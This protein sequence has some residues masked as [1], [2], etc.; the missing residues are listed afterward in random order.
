M[1]V[2]IILARCGSKG[3]VDK[4]I[5]QV[6]SEKLS[7]I[8]TLAAVESDIFDKIIYSSDS[9]A[10]LEMARHRFGSKISYH[11]RTTEAAGDNVSSWSAVEEVVTDMLEEIDHHITLLGGSCATINAQD[12]YLFE[13]KC[14]EA[15]HHGE[16]LSVKRVSYP[17][18]NTF[19][20][21]KNRIV[22]HQ[23]SRKLACR[24]EAKHIWQ[25]DGHIYKR[26]I[27]RLGEPF[28]NI[29]TLP[30]SLSKKIYINV[31]TQEDLLLAQLLMGDSGI[32]RNTF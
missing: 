25:P 26:I 31:D 19:L 17:L 32:N 15:S 29:H 16:A 9:E 24:Q 1:T 23:L 6:G 7:H 21:E 27:S 30:I 12:L 13:R 8:P 4:N 20:I 5:T 22:K 10:Y 11:H 18:E 14:A 28:P 3:V 2:A